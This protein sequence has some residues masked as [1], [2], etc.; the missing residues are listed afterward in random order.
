MVSR[1]NGE[2]H[3]RAMNEAGQEIAANAGGA[4]AIEPFHGEA[5]EWDAFVAGA[6]GSSF[7]H[8][9]GWRDIMTGVMGHE[10]I[11]LVARDE[12]Q[13][14]AGA[15]PLVRV[16]SRLMGHYLVSMPFLN[17]GGPVGRPVA[18]SALASHAAELAM[19]SSVDLLEL[20]TRHEVTTE[21][22]VAQRKVLV[23]LALP[24]DPQNLWRERFPSKLRS[25]IR[26]P[27]K[28][29]L[30]ARFG[31]EH[32]PAFYHVFARHMRDL[33]TP[34]L[35]RAFFEALPRLFPEQVRFGVV[36]RGDEPCAAGCGFI[37][38]DELE[39]TWAS[40]LLEYKRN[41]PN[42]LLYWAFMEQAIAEGMQT[43][44]FGRSSPGTGP[45]RFKTQW[46]G[47][48]VPLP[49]LQ[50]SRGP[51]KA[52]PTP[53]ASTLFRMATA[54]WKRVPVGLATRLGPYLARKIP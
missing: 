24:A 50:W 7:S 11:Y 40:S 22:R 38:R 42:M 13:A 44:N 5:A 25:Q 21:L 34:V 8:L 9:A 2:N 27:Q 30:V 20:R 23:L 31:V 43:F 49:W 29:G 6:S 28:D 32:L 10:C 46:G 54:V 12:D 35:P 4:L 37:W 17:Y 1:P 18:C 53:D 15:L 33:G 19:G 41:A 36:Y 14:W 51:M 47:A 48:D 3:G 39:M 16:K 26:R 52:T 45:H